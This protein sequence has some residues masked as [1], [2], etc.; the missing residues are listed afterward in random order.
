MSENFDD[1]FQDDGFDIDNEFS[2]GDADDGMPPLPDEPGGVSRSF[3]I[4]G[5]LLATVF[6]ILVAI[7]AA[8]VLGGRDECDD[9]CILAT[10]IAGTNFYI[11]TEVSVSETALST[12]STATTIAE[13]TSVAQTATQESINA[14]ASQEAIDAA[15][16]ATDTQIAIDTTRT[17]VAEFINQTATAE[18]AFTDTPAPADVVLQI[19]DMNGAPLRGVTVCVFLDDGDGVFNPGGETTADCSA[20]ALIAPQPGEGGGPAEA[21]TEV[22]T[23]APTGGSGLSPIFQTATAQAGGVSAPVPTTAPTT[24]PAG[25]S[26]ISPIFQTATA[27]A[28]GGAAAPIEAPV[29]TEEVAPPPSSGGQSNLNPIFQT[30]TA[31]AAGSSGGASS[32][33]EGDAGS[34]NFGPPSPTPEGASF[35]PA[36]YQPIGRSIDEPLRRDLPQQQGGDDFIDEIITNSDG[37][38]TLPQLPVGRYW[39]KIA[40]QTIPIDVT[41]EPQLITV[42]QADPNAPPIQIVVPAAVEGLGGGSTQPTEI[43]AQTTLGPLFQT[44][45]AVALARQ[46][47]GPTQEVIGPTETPSMPGTGLFSGDSNE[48][49]TTDLFILAVIG[50]VLIGIV[51]AARRMRQ[52]V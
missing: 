20:T 39:I 18:A 44:G 29:E 28:G 22:P 35:N 36:L 41:T 6:V 51:F 27:Q 24:A 31:S 1:F 2:L 38:I 37:R 5:A 50:S 17:Q 43:P 16:E 34:S 40:D 33:T 12:Q 45:T 7:I 52:T 32:N 15:V 14:T 13:Q 49:T 47:G 4:I 21:S 25:G 23:T 30:A 46:T 19:R 48:V 42:P 3:I 9:R 26:G 11:E 10:S 8:V